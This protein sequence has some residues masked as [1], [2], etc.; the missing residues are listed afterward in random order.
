ME[1]VSA[2]ILSTNLVALALILSVLARPWNSK[3]LAAPPAWAVIP[4][5]ILSRGDHDCGAMSE[6]DGRH[7]V[8]P[9]PGPY[10]AVLP[11]GLAHLQYRQV[12]VSRP[13]GM[14][15]LEFGRQA[16]HARRE[17]PF[18]LRQPSNWSWT[19]WSRSTASTPRYSLGTRRPI[20][21]AGAAHLRRCH[22]Y[23]DPL[24]ESAGKNVG[25]ISVFGRLTQ[26]DL[27]FRRVSLSS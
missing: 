26:E 7:P 1:P 3:L 14:P 8:D 13:K 19:R 18:R 20:A 25:E 10:Q 12:K 17:R 4:T 24:A 2:F 23:D 21:T 22:D 6:P 11:S 15:G 16:P 27:V 5:S 9:G